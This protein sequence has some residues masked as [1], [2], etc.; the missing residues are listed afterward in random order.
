MKKVF[1]IALGVVTSI[2]GLMGRVDGIVIDTSGSSRPQVIEIE[3][4]AAMLVRRLPRP[5]S[6]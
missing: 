5:I 3:I 2:G 1:E 4:G 6:N